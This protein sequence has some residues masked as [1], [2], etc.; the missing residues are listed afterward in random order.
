M[1]RQRTGRARRRWATGL[2]LGCAL[3][4]WPAASGRVAA[5]RAGFSGK[6]EVRQIEIG[7]QLNRESLK[8]RVTLITS[9]AVDH[10]TKNDV[11]IQRI[12]A[13]ARM[14][15]EGRAKLFAELSGNELVALDVSVP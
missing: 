2:A 13:M 15:A 4:T 9:M 1:G 5:Q 11:D 14:F 3:A 8:I 10:E 12:F 7:H 6:I